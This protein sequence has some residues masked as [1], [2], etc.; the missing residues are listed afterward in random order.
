MIRILNIS[1]EEDTELLSYEE[2]SKLS[3]D[4][5]IEYFIFWENKLMKEITVLANLIA[6]RNAKIN[7]TGETL[8]KALGSID[9]RVLRVEQQKIAEK[10][11]IQD[12]LKGVIKP[13]ILRRSWYDRMEE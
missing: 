6:E 9:S 5:K 8:E 3:D 13:N 2:F 12:V 11:L 1:K 7:S 10:S 4:D